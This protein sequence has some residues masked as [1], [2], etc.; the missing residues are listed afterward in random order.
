MELDAGAELNAVE[1]RAASVEMAAG[2]VENVAAGGWPGGEEGWWVAALERGR[3][4]GRRLV[5][6]GGAAVWSR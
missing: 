2:A 4:R 3:E 1:W 5:G 6:R